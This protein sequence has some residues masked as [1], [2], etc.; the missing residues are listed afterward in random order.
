MSISNNIIENPEDNDLNY[1]EQNIDKNEYIKSLEISVQLLQREIENLRTQLTESRAQGDIE[2]VANSDNPYSILSKFNSRISLIKKLDQILDEKF[3]FLENSI[4]EVDHKSKLIPYYS[5]PKLDSFYK[6]SKNLEEDGI[7]DWVAGTGEIQIVPNLEES[8][9]KTVVNNVI[10]YIRIKG[11]RDSVFIAKTTKSKTQ[12]SPLVLKDLEKLITAT[13]I[14]LD[15]I[16]SKEEIKKINEDIAEKSHSNSGASIYNIATGV[17]ENIYQALGIID[18]N[19]KMIESGIGD[20]KRRVELIN[21]NSNKIRETGKKFINLLY[22]NNSVR[23]KDSLKNI[24]NDVIFLIK[25]QLLRDGIKILDNLDEKINVTINIAFLEKTILNILLVIRD[26][27]KDGGLIEFS[28]NQS[29][30]NIILKISDNSI[31]LPIEILESFN[32]GNKILGEWEELFSKLSGIKDS[33]IKESCN[34]EISSK[35]RAGTTYS[36]YLKN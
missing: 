7:I 22:D 11:F 28:A 3:N 17:V 31:G 30:K 9:E 16:I 6:Y 8:T 14:L 1:N 32:Q 29:N 2:Q 12:F 24:I 34:L 13:T 5:D 20:S 4:F 15:N 36:I 23:N 35:E 10:Y 25:S 26:T 27:L 18:A 33:L 19:V 21:E